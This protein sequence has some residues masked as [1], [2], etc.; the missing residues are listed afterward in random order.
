MMP[1]AQNATIRLEPQTHV[2]T[3]NFQ[4]NGQFCERQEMVLSSLFGRPAGRTHQRVIGVRTGCRD[5][6]DTVSSN[7]DGACCCPVNNL[8]M[9]GDHFCLLVSSRRMQM[10]SAC[11]VVIHLAAAF[12]GVVSMDEVIMEWRRIEGSVEGTLRRPFLPLAYFSS[13]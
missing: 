7:I 13:S 3:L 8:M 12:S 9:F 10:I 1:A 4:G 2:K 11:N 5:Q 6:L